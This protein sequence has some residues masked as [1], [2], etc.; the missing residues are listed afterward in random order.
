[1]APLGPLKGCERGWIPSRNLCPAPGPDG[2]T[3]V[4]GQVAR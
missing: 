1:M 2:G 4:P 3:E